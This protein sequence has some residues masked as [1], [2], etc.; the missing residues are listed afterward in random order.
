MSGEIEGIT[1]ALY[2]VIMWSYPISG[3]HVNP[4]VTLGIYAKGFGNYEKNFPMFITILAGEF[5]GG[6][7]GAGVFKWLHDQPTGG[8]NMFQSTIQLKAIL[9]PRPGFDVGRVFFLEMLCTG[10]FVFAVCLIKFSNTS[11]FVSE[12]PFLKVGYAMVMLMMA[13]HCCGWATGG[14]LNPAVGIAQVWLASEI[15]EDVE[16]GDNYWLYIVP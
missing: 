14:C 16:Q 9:F 11:R 15:L 6:F 10:F 13:L 1:L 7:C 3:G 5:A 8:S 12:V 4:A 2:A